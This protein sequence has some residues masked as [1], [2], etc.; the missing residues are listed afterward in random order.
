MQIETLSSE[1]YGQAGA[2]TVRRVGWHDICRPRNVASIEQ[3]NKF[4][5]KLASINQSS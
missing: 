2:T 3:Y 5:E 1:Q 4:V